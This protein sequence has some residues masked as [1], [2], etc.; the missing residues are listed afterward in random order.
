MVLYLLRN[1]NF[2]ASRYDEDL[3]RFEPDIQIEALESVFVFNPTATTVTMTMLGEVKT[4]R[5]EYNYAPGFHLTNAQI[6]VPGPISSA[7]KLPDVPGTMV[8]LLGPTGY[9]V[10]VNDE[11]GGGWLPSEPVLKA[12]TAFWLYVPERVAW[13]WEFN[14]PQ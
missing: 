11:F 2:V 3:G 1:G 12:G 10:Y 4:G 14:P 7:M 13:S 6:P 5:L 8:Y 9:T